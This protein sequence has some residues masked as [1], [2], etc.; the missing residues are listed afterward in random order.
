M[1][2]GFVAWIQEHPDISL[3]GGAVAVL[4]IAGQLMKPKT[5]ATTA[6]QSDLSG[7][8]NGIVYVPTQ[9]SFTTVNKAG[10]SINSPVSTTTTT[11]NPPPVFHPGPPPVRVPPPPPAPPPPTTKSLK[12]DQHWQILG[13]QNLSMI[14][15]MLT[16]RLRA[17]G[18]PGSMSITWTD[19]WNYNQALITR[20]ANQHGH[21]QNVYNWVFPGESLT[22]PRWG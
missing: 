20:Y 13:G 11:T 16:T 7:L 14:A 17:Q 22:V 12:W 5:P 4:L 18:M 6:P 15:G 3:A 9:T 2:N 10:G 1:A 21:Y 19:L 8:T